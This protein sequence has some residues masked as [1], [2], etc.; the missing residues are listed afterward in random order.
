MPARKDPRIDAYIRRAQPFAKPILV[1]IRTV[2]HR[3]LPD[4][5]ET[6]KWG[7]PAYLAGG[8]IVCGMA[9]FKAH[10]ALWFWNGKALVTAG[11]LKAAWNGPGMGS[12]GKL[13]KVADLP[14]AGVLAAAV[15]KAASRRAG[16]DGARRTRN[17]GAAT[18]R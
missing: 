15:R 13:R 1:R 9:G 4:V 18:S 11:I 7:M 10:A 12:F 17:K 6:I 5:E 2:V 16:P 3:G 14:P 8:K